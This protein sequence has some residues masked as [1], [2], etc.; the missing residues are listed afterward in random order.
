ATTAAGLN[1]DDYASANIGDGLI[2]EDPELDHLIIDTDHSNLH[3]IPSN[4]TLRDA[5]HELVAQ[6]EPL[7]R[8]S[9]GLQKLEGRY[10]YVIIDLPPTI[11]ILQEMAIEAADRFVIPVELARFSL[12]GLGKVVLHLMTRKPTDTQWQFRIV[13]SRVEG[14]NKLSNEQATKDLRDLKRYILPT[15]IRYN[16][17]I[18]L[19]QTAGKDIFTFAPLSRGARDFRHLCK[20]IETLWPTTAL[21][22][23]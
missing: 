12:D 18:P 9:E 13:L 19:S 23:S 6:G 14:Y 20:D 16:G 7:E 8:L 4:R 10:Q 15:A 1:P 22:A 2:V 17:K 21:Q 11:E 3:L 5:A